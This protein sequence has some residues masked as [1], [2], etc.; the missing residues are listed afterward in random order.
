ML[1][2]KVIVGNLVALGD[3]ISE[4]DLLQ[5]MLRGLGIKYNNFVTNIITREVF[6]SINVVHGYF[7]GFNKMLQEQSPSEYEYFHANVV[8]FQ[9]K[10]ANFKF[11]N[12]KGSESKSCWTF[13]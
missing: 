13:K 5:Y 2:V 9:G 11:S 8:K 1:K 4:K 3:P 10:N 7:E 12:N 6:P